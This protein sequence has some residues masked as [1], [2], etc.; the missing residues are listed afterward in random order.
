M[1]GDE[2]TAGTQSPPRPAPIAVQHRLSRHHLDLLAAGG[3]DAST[4][5][6]LLASER[7]WR[8]LMLRSVL[9]A[10]RSR[11]DATGPLPSLDTAWDLLVRAERRDPAEVGSLVLYPQVGT[12]ASYALR[13]LRQAVPADTPLWVDVGYLH[14]VAAVAAL[15]AGLEFTIRVPV[16]EGLAILPTV[17][18]AELPARSGWGYA[19]V[20]AAGGD[21]T[22]TGAD[23]TVRLPAPGAASDGWLPLRT[24][25]TEASGVTL[26]LVLDDIDPYRNLRAPTS[27]E[28]LST[29]QAERWHSLLAE[30]WRLITG[31]SPELAAPMARGLFSI[32]PWPAAQRFRT[33]SASA[34]D[35]F[36]NA[37]VSELDDP[38]EL[39]VTL[40]H[41]FQHIKLGGLL[42]L[43]P[44]HDREPAQHLYAPWRDDPRP[45]GGL[46]QGVYAFTGVTNF[47]R[48]VRRV[49]TG[50]TGDVAQFEFARW[51]Q[52]V[53]ATLRQLRSLPELTDLGRRLLAGLTTT[54]DGWTD[55]HVPADLAAAADAAVADHRARWQI[56][57]VRWHPRSVAELAAAYAAGADRPAVDPPPSSVET[58]TAARGLDTLAVLTRWRLAD[59][60]GFAGLGQ[61]RAGVGRHVAGATAAD[62]AV[63]SG[64]LAQARRL[65]LV[66]L[67]ADPDHVGAWSGLGL[68]ESASRPGPGTAALQAWPGLVRAVHRAVRTE[69]GSAP[70]PLA[71]ANWLGPP[72]RAR[73]A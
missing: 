28:Y 63:V 13:R 30:A 69:S 27:P 71:L 33:M 36:G 14:A 1:A 38:V 44:L 29:V 42:H 58:D 9:N 53:W 16:R 62:L 43:A 19:E 25:R 50:N 21:A 22:V 59:P 5:S 57:H 18:G 73:S 6:E 55:Q 56:H 41:E 48:A 49:A 31:A 52:E 60:A 61:D 15:R 7:S 26:S 20:R 68:G 67:A 45:L 23:T 11:P 66:Q 54:A 35:A 70:D 37:I 4:V 12:W 3:G 46:L 32:A 2:V 10:A 65:H 64:K 8:L 34:G 51:R 39:A 40:V 24:I 47:W 72:N 17:G